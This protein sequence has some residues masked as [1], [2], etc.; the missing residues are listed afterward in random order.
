MLAN[1]KVR[2][3]LVA[4]TGTT[5]V[6]FA[7]ALVI[8]V[9]A[10]QRSKESFASF[11]AHDSARL[12][13]FNEMYAQGLQGGQALRNIMLDP[14]NRKA[15]DNL[16]LAVSDFDAALSKARTLSA[17]HPEIGQRV[18]EIAKLAQQQQV[19]RTA[20]LAEVSA[21]RL[22]EAK[23]RLIKDETPAWR[24]LKKE[25]LE[26]IERLAK[27]AAATEEALANETSRKQMQIAFAAGFAMLTMLAIS[28]L[29]GRNLLRQLG[30]EPTYAVNAMYRLA[31]GDLTQNIT[32]KK[33]DETS[34]LA[35]IHKTTQSLTHIIGEVITNAHGLSNSTDQVSV[36]AQALS[37]SSSQQAASVEETSASIEEMAASI[38]QNSDNARVTNDMASRAAMQATEGGVA[39]KETVEAMKQIANKIGIIDDIAYQ[40]NLLALNAAIEAARAGDAGK[41]FAV[42][43]AEVRKL[44]ERSQVASQEIG[45]VASSSVK[46]AEKAGSLLDEMLPSIRK[47]SD[48]VQE[49]AAASQEQSTGVSQIYGEMGQLNQATQHNASASEELAATA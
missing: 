36:T 12:A 7:I 49:I 18:N 30:G 10:M 22:D 24:A 9:M 25:V 29:I 20:V 15:Y 17:D 8:A 14:A 28:Y 38:N 19:A 4:L 34:L 31:E 21:S 42:V 43:A 26:G 3:Q 13:A 11:I 35:A 39:V 33:G 23:T 5:L 46:L 44:A 37:Q 41:G 47:T 27:E 48:L 16:N 45:Q 2:T 32:L 6:L 1:L 40:T